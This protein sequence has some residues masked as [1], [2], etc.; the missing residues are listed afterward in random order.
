MGVKLLVRTVTTW[1]WR[2]KEVHI[3]YRV[4]Q[5]D[6]RG[7]DNL[8]YTI[9]LRQEYMYFLFNRTTLQ[10]FV[11]YLTGALYMHPLWF[12][13]H[14]H[15]NRV[16]SKLF[17]ACQ[18]WR[19][20]W[21]SSSG[22]HTYPVSCNCAYHLRMELSDG[23]CFPNLVRNCRWTIVPRQSFWITLYVTTCLLFPT[24]HFHMLS[25]VSLFLRST[26]YSHVAQSP[27]RLNIPR[28]HLLYVVL[29]KE[30]ALSHCKFVYS[31]QLLCSSLEGQNVLYSI[32]YRH[33]L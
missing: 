3:I 22:I 29:I 6:C 17:V 23:G 26:E 14:Q 19:F 28:W 18:R 5:N 20:Q 15:D 12:Y 30:R 13:K 27:W 11:T 33:T 31:A 7:F 25:V 2:V 16:R 10:I 8:S 1:L 4:I 32:W 21:R 9:H 24:S